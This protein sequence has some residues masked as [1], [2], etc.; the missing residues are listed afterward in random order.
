MWLSADAPPPTPD[1]A[2]LLAD[3]GPPVFGFVP[4]PRL[5]ERGWSWFARDGVILEA[6]AHYW[7]DVANDGHESVVEPHITELRG[8]VFTDAVGSTGS[9]HD[10]LHAALVQHLD[11]I[12][13][14]YQKS[15]YAPGTP[16]WADHGVSRRSAIDTA[17][18]EPATL[19]IVDDVAASAA[20][21]TRVVPAV[22]VS[23][24]SFSAS[25]ALVDGRIVAV[26][27]H[28]A[29]RAAIDIRLARRL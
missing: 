27:I 16:Q 18:V 24:T 3:F 17:R 20:A 2:A 10:P 22:C 19:E 8:Y 21:G 4:Q 14:N 11:Y 26:V 6:Q 23:T 9:S 25:A 15:R 13:G 29:D 12:V 1:D 28:H 7:L 5:R